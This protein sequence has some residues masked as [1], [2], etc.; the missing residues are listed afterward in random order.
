MITSLVDGS[1]YYKKYSH[2]GG[3][4]PVVL[5]YHGNIKED[6]IAKKQGIPI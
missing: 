4:Y 5:A 2:C 3:L 6:P 1:F